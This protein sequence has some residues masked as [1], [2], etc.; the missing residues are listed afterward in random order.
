MDAFLDVL[1]AK[2]AKR[3][4]C[5][6]LHCGL[7]MGIDRPSVTML[8][9]YSQGKITETLVKKLTSLDVTATRKRARN[10]NEASSQRCTLTAT[11]LSKNMAAQKKN[12]GRA[13][14]SPSIG[15]LFFAAS[16]QMTSIAECSI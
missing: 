11:E 12:T 5:V 13:V 3:K 15:F 2:T 4:E 7:S 1:V 6:P 16:P 10:V 8:L 9:L 14:H